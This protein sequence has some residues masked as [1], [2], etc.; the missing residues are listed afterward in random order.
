MNDENQSRKK[1]RPEDE[2]RAISG[3]ILPLTFVDY[4]NV[5]FDESFLKRI[6]T[7]VTLFAG[8]LTEARVFREALTE[9][10]N[11]H[12][13]VIAIDKNQPDK[14]QP[15]V[16]FVQSDVFEFVATQPDDSADLITAYGAEYL[17]EASAFGE[18]PEYPKYIAI[19][20]QHIPRILKSGGVFH[21]PHFAS[22]IF[23]GDDRLVEVDE[24]VFRKK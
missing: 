9:A 14:N 19:I 1:H 24:D 7:V 4:L 5:M 3:D 2:R 21:G 8:N 10:G 6:S 22:K 17:F 16:E 18:N 15:D 13:K 12:A 23:A 11:T 20:Q